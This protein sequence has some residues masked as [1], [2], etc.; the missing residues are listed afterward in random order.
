MI[1]PL[2]LSYDLACPPA[3]AFTVWTTRLSLW[4]PKGHTVSGDPDTV[5]TLEPRLGGR[6]FERTPEG[7]EHDFGVIT[8]WE[9]P[10]RLG[11]L[12][13]IR[14]PASEATDVALSFIEAGAGR[15]RL[16]IVH[17]GW[18]RLGAEAQAWRDANTSGWNALLPGLLIALHA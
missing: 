16:E 4:W 7:A 15:T 14:R 8:A 18:E 1:E 12:W 3:H 9:P 17:S 6:I 2:R 5:V 11:Y 10:Y 13:H